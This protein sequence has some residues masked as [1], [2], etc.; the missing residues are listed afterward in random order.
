MKTIIKDATIVN[1]GRQYRGSIIIENDK[2]LKIEPQSG[3]ST[4]EECDTIIDARGMYLLPGVI[5]DHVHF[6]EPGLTEKATIY[7]ESRAAAAG[8]VTSFM[9]M[10]NTKPQTT[11]IE[12]LEEKFAIA[13]KESA[14]NY[15]FYFGATNDNSDLFNKL[16]PGEVCGIKLFMGASTGNMLVDDKDKLGKI[17]SYTNMPI[18]VHC[19]DCNIIAQNTRRIT[20]QVGASAGVEYHPIIRS[21]E[22]CY[23]STEL[24]I[25]LAKQYGSRLHIMHISTK[26]E[27]KLLE[28]ADSCKITAEATPAH[29]YFCD[30]DYKSLG[31]KIKCN[32][33]IKSAT[34]R[35]ALRDAIKDGKIALIG[36][37]H[38]PHCIEDKE[39]G[40]LTAASGIPTIQFS[41]L[42]MLEMCD[43][44]IF[45][46][47][48][49][50]ERMCHAPSRIFNI[51][52]RGYIREGY[53]AD[54][55]LLQPESPHTITAKNIISKCGWSPFEGHTFNWKVKQT[56]INGQC[57]YNDGE[58]AED[59]HG[60]KLVFNR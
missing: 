12:A 3:K 23:K 26:E 15:S 46:I 37:D 4:T 30:E 36:T 40:A 21:A 58:I 45:T 6:R 39:G 10:P 47:E 14:I 20:E 44:N 11:T 49:I 8:G 7:S 24:A 42:A 28:D 33:A 57:I 48:D 35:A 27:L 22:A 18:A 60:R 50:A 31:T 59:A 41:L 13:E 25:E 5:D 38:A 16:S 29:L 34:D 55:I 2:I 19:E 9:E 1:E 54:F 53:F 17:F 56:W 43:N 32:P 52:R 51:D